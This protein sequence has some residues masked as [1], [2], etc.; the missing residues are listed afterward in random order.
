VVNTIE[1]VLLGAHQSPQPKQQIDQ[2]SH[3]CTAHGR[4]SMGA[5]FPKNCPFPWKIKTHIHNSWFL[6]PVWGQNP[7]G[8]TTGC[9]VQL[10]L[11]RWLQSLPIFYN[12]SP[13]SPLKTAPSL[14][15]L[16]L[17]PIG[18]IYVRSTGDAA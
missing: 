6:G 15:D 8:I 7:N 12:G 13:L 17:N 16:D 9:S 14:G 18:H 5:P 10:F 11:H 3:F 4:K 1:V 2:F